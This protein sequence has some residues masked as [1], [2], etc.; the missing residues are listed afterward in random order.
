MG[1]V[2]TVI[3][4]AVNIKERSARGLGVFYQ[5]SKPLAGNSIVYVSAVKNKHCHETYIFKAILDNSGYPIGFDT[6]QELA[7]SLKNVY[8]HEA[9]LWCAGEYV[10]EGW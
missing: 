3:K 1:A 9:A 7:G 5:L 4:V 6:D 10:V 8:D 2:A